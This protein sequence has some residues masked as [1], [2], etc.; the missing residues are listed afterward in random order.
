MCDIT[1][2]RN[3]GLV[4]TA[5]RRPVSAAAAERLHAVNVPPAYTSACYSADPRADLLATAVSPSGKKQYF[6]SPSHNQMASDAKEER[7]RKFAGKL[8]HIRRRVRAMV[9]RGDDRGIA[10]HVLD[11]CG[12]RPGLRGGGDLTGRHFRN[13]VAR[14]T[15]KAGVPQSCDMRGSGVVSMGQ[16]RRYGGASPEQL[17]EAMGEFQLKDWRT[18]R[19]NVRFLEHWMRAPR[20]MTKRTWRDVIAATAADNGHTPAVFRNHYLLPR[21][22]TFATADHKKNRFTGDAE[23]LLIRILR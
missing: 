6:Y 12:I 9:E 23:R 8:K 11:H 5:S 13:G 16:L 2:T 15:G 4:Y 17:R 7:L 19:A 21:V 14:F 20:P 10:L 18:W 22:H 3:G 1:R